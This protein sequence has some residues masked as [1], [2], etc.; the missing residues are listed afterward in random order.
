MAEKILLLNKYLTISAIASPKSG[1]N[2]ALNPGRVDVTV[3]TKMPSITPETAAVNKTYTKPQAR[4]ETA[5]G[6]PELF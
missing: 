2:I 6:L 1:N 5:M 3:S 4:Q